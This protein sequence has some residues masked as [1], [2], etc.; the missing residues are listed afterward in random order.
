VSKVLEAHGFTPPLFVQ[1]P[2]GLCVAV[3]SRPRL[4]P[5]SPSS[6]TSGYEILQAKVATTSENHVTLELVPYFL[7][8]SGYAILGK[9]FE[10]GIVRERADIAQQLRAELTRN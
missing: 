3:C 9:L 5:L 8:A 4:K 7:V 1:K 10:D 2:H 6:T